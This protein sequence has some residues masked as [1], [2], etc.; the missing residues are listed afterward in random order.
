MSLIDDKTI[1]EFTKDPL[2]LKE[3]NYFF[4]ALQSM[5]EEEKRMLEKSCSPF[6][7]DIF[8]SVCIVEEKVKTKNNYQKATIR[9]MLKDQE[10]FLPIGQFP[11]K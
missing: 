6:V 4:K 2:G 7:E 3:E 8:S 5:T 9:E 1:E 11:E 10:N